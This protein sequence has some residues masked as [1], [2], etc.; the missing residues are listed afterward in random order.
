MAIKDARRQ[1]LLIAVKE[2]A[3]LINTA[4]KPIIYF[5]GRIAILVGTFD[6]IPAVTSSGSSTS[7]GPGRPL[8]LSMSQPCTKWNV[9]VRKTE[10]LAQRIREAFEIATSCHIGRDF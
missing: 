6:R 10:E 5:W 8:V 1:E 9:S 3:N 7:T 2:A 4:Q